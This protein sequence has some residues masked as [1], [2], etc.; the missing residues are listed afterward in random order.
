M[1]PEVDGFQVLKSIREKE[2]TSQLPVLILTAKH[3]T[4]EELKFL[5]HNHVQQFIQK[6]D[7]NANEM[8]RAVANML[9]PETLESDTPK[10]ETLSADR[11]A[12]TIEGKPLVLIVEDNPDNM[13]SVKALLSD[14]FTVLEAVNGMEGVEKAERFKP[15][16]ILMDIA[17]P[18]MDGIEAF[19]IIRNEPGLQHIKVIALTASAMTRDREIVLS[20]GFDAFIAKPIDEQEFF[21]TI[22]TTLYGK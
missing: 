20:H 3:I 22:N 9:F 6:G 7:V 13:L 4:K 5:K 21:D 18:Q 14:D 17:L 12:R 1:M 16:L 11:Q 19:K 10:P 15:N 8:L 2:Q